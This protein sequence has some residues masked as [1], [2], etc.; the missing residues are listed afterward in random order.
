[1]FSRY[2]VM[3]ESEVLDSDDKLP[4]PDPLTINYNDTQLTQ[5]PKRRELSMPD[6]QRFWLFMIKQYRSVAEGD[7]ILLTLNN[8][9]YRGM[10]VPGDQL[11]VID[12]ADLYG[13]GTL[14][15]PS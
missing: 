8:I 2:N 14:K 4:Y 11:Y 6:I 3:S 9:P 10:L 5:M 1:M 12:S 15:K 13:F 7:D